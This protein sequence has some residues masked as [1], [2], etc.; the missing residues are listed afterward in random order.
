MSCAICKYNHVNICTNIKSYYAYKTIS[1]DKSCK[2]YEFYKFEELNNIR[3]NKG[4]LNYGI[5]R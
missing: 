2:F 4:V 1:E 5:C 3:K